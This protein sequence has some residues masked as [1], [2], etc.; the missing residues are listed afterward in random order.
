MIG[1]ELDLALF[2]YT[3]FCFVLDHCIAMIASA[4]H[5]KCDPTRANEAL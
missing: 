2:A 5:D 1:N 4:E 3:L